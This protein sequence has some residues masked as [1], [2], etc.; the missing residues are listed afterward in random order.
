MS[1]CKSKEWI[2]CRK[3]NLIKTV[4]PRRKEL[5]HCGLSRFTHRIRN[6]FLEKCMIMGFYSVLEQSQSCWIFFARNERE[7]NIKGN[8]KTNI[9]GW[10][11]H[12]C[13]MQEDQVQVPALHQ[14]TPLWLWIKLSLRNFSWV[15]WDLLSPQILCLHLIV[16]LRVFP[17][18]AESGWFSVQLGP[19]PTALITEVDAFCVWIMAV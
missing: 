6:L 5:H 19:D 4:V 2:I 12:S 9:R 14:G 1:Q 18:L 7:T 15:S 10:L 17:P 11:W 3:A 16:G 8:I 13:G